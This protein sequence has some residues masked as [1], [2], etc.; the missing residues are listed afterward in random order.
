[1]IETANDKRP[2]TV[3]HG[4]AF[5]ESIQ[6]LIDE[7]EERNYFEHLTEYVSEICEMARKHVVRLD[8]GYFKIVMALKVAEGIALSL[9]REIDL[10]TKCVPIVMK[11][12]AMRQL[13]LQQF[14]LPESDDEFMQQTSKGGK[15]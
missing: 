1:M 9:N 10:I 14:P 6:R 5:C 15:K 2:D 7:T 13:G 4:D 11:T 12:R 3:K 8:P